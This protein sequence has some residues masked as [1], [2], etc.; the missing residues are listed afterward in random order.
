MSI[1]E[2]RMLLIA[3][4]GLVSA[5]M[6]GCGKKCASKV[7][8]GGVTCGGANVP[9]GTVRLISID[10]GVA[11]RMTQ[12]VGGH[13]QFDGR[14]SVPL[15]KWR[16]EIDARKRTGR[17]VKGNN[18]FETTMVDE[19]VRVGPEVYAAPQSPLVVDVTADFDGKLDIAIPAN[20][21]GFVSTERE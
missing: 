15:G 4:A 2:N 3:V 20:N 13:Y 21:R 8:E 14:N 6:L 16:I 10:G 9:L 12:I 17:R 11:P 18:G 19:E 5:A 7:V 1:P